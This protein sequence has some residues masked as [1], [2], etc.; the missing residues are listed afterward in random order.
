MGRF[1]AFL[2]A[3][4]LVGAS[5]S[6]SGVRTRGRRSDGPG[7]A[8]PDSVPGSG[9]GP[10]HRRTRRGARSHCAR[11]VGN[12]VTPIETVAEGNS[13][14]VRVTSVIARQ[15]IRAMDKA[16]R[17]RAR[18]SKTTMRLSSRRATMSLERTRELTF[19]AT[20]S[21]RPSATSCPSKSRIAGQA[22]DPQAEQ[23]DR[24]AVAFR[25]DQGEGEDGVQECGVADHGRGMG[26]EA[27]GTALIDRLVAAIPGPFGVLAQVLQD[28][29]GHGAC[30]RQPSHG[31]WR[32]CRPSTPWSEDAKP[33]VNR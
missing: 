17:L 21:T 4:L 22:V 31:L 20:S 12:S 30:G 29:R 2:L 25:L 3:G 6:S 15:M 11:L 8:R 14:T 9:P 1:K 16:L 32:Q 7:P 24:L 26:L 10:V 19:R 13:G 18:I 28:A 5:R 33:A 23:G 27:P